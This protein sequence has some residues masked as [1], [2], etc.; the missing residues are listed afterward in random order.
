MRDSGLRGSCPPSGRKQFVNMKWETWRENAGEKTRE[1]R[2]GNGPSSR[3]AGME[4]RERGAVGLALSFSWPTGLLGATARR[5]SVVHGPGNPAG[6]LGK[7]AT[8][9][10]KGTKWNSGDSESIYWG[11]AELSCAGA[12]RA[13]FFT[14]CAHSGLTKALGTQE[15]P[16]HDLAAP[17][18]HNHSLSCPRGLLCVSP[19]ATV[20]L[21]KV[22]TVCSVCSLAAQNPEVRGIKGFSCE[23]DPMAAVVL[24]WESGKDT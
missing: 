13:D 1:G 6:R 15:Q 8:R 21:A 9:H 22:I 18:Q 11:H 17:K 5:R 10:F 16:L 24:D 23:G 19:R 3:V 4:P 7:S 2:T 12:T 20:S 14:S